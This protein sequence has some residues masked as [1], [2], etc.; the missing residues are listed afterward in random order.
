MSPQ[1]EPPQLVGALS[2][3]FPQ[4]AVAT[5][6]LLGKVSWVFALSKPAPEFVLPDV[7]SFHPPAPAQSDGA[8]G[9]G[10]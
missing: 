4:P 3:L 8:A 10:P 6:E 2:L 1:P 7:A 9:A 5:D